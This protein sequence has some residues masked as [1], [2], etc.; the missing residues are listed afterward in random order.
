MMELWIDT[1]NTKLIKE[2]KEMGL[3]HGVT[4]NPSILS[5]AI[6]PV[7][8]VLQE[9][10][11]IQEGPLT[12]QVEA[13]TAEEM[14]EQGK[15]FHAFSPRVI[16]KV[17][18]TP[19]GLKA[20]HVLSKQKIKTMA[21]VIFHSRQ[22]LLA[23]MAGAD[24][25]APYVSRMLMSDENAMTQLHSMM[26]IVRNYQFKTKILA[27]SLRTLDQISLCVEMGLHAITLKD[28]VFSQMTE[29]HE[30][31]LKTAQEMLAKR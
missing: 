5:K 23:A 27:A 9:I 17:P 14:I 22:V 18:V 11:S 26:H 15:K 21:T 25:A 8:K 16:V 7:E 24:Y 12:I 3:L 28:D 2:A 6:G 10:L 31:T 30:L 20:I 1:I 19:E 13:E 29:A 4:T